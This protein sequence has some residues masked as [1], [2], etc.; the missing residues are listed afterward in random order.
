M[1]LGMEIQQVSLAALVIVL[2]M[3][4]DDAI[5]VVDNYV[6]KLDE[7][8]DRWQAAWRSATDDLF[9]PVLAATAAIIFAFLPSAIVYTGL[10]REF[11]LHIPATVAVALTASLLGVDAAHALVVLLRHSQGACTSQKAVD[12]PAAKPSVI[13]RVQG[14]FNRAV[15][16]S[17]RPPQAGAHA[18]LCLARVCRRVRLAGKV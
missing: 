6:E 5:V 12:A 14:R 8:M 10:T 13:D 4:V 11:S 17:L 15:D 2:G 7:G 16:W 18:G 1:L 9:V 3:V